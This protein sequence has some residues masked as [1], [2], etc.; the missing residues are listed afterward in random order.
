MIFQ[1]RINNSHDI[2]FNEYFAWDLISNLA[3]VIVY[4]NILIEILILKHWLFKN[5]K[6]WSIQ[7]IFSGELNIYINAFVQPYMNT[8]QFSQQ[9]KKKNTCQCHSQK[10]WINTSHWC[11]MVMNRL[12]WIGTLL[13]TMIALLNKH[14]EVV[15]SNQ[16]CSCEMKCVEI[17]AFHVSFGSFW[18]NIPQWY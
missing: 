15:C 6:T 8:C 14:T 18:L 5:I 10:L 13:I 11:C 12:T 7:L 1:K 4:K 2:F 3:I 9:K 16:L 17:Q